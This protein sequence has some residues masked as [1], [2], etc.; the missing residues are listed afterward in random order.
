MLRYEQCGDEMELMYGGMAWYGMVW[1][2]V[3]INHHSTIIY[4]P[5]V[6]NSSKTRSSFTSWREIRVQG[7]VR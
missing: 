2:G 4:F 6:R 5:G 1:Y 7:I 3:N